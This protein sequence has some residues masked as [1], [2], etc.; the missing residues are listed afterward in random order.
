[1]NTDRV[2][3]DPDDRTYTMPDEGEVP[4]VDIVEI[5]W[6]PLAADVRVAGILVSPDR[7]KALAT[8]ANRREPLHGT[9]LFQSVL[10]VADDTLSNDLVLTFAEDGTIIGGFHI[11]PAEP[12]R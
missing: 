12:A 8:L 5:P 7:L 1:M 10:V 6:T 3:S 9:L 11:V 4:I 2:G